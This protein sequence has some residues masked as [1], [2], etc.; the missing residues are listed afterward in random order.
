MRNLIIIN[1]SEGAALIRSARVLDAFFWRVGRSTW[2]G[3]ASDA[4]LKRVAKELRARASRNTAVAFHVAREGSDYRDPILVVGSRSS[5]GPRGV[6]PVSRRKAPEMPAPSPARRRSAAVLRV[7]ALLHDLGKAGSDFQRKLD[8]S[9]GDPA[10][11]I[12]DQARH[13]LISFALWDVAYGGMDDETLGAA[14]RAYDPAAITSAWESLGSRKMVGRYFARSEMLEK[15]ILATCLPSSGLSRT[16]GLL[17]LSHHRLPASDGEH[18]LS[19]GNHVR[20][21]DERGRIPAIGY[22]DPGPDGPFWA[23]PAFVAA[24]RAAGEA[25]TPGPVLMPDLVLRTALMLG[26]HHGSSLKSPSAER[27]AHVANLIGGEWADGLDVHTDRV[28][29]WSSAALRALEGSFPEIRPRD[30]PDGVARP[31]IEGLYG[32]QGRAAAA[33]AEVAAEGAAFFACVISGTGTGKTFGLPAI[34]AAAAR[35]HPDPAMRGLRFFLGQGLRT[36]ST[37]SARA[38]V[39]DAGFPASAVRAAVGRPVVRIPDAGEAQGS[40]SLD[41]T[42]DLTSAAVGAEMIAEPLPAPLDVMFPDPGDA[43][44]IA[45]PIVAGTIDQIAASAT[46]LR[47]F[48]LSASV[49]VI[50]SDLMLDEIDQLAPEQLFIAYALIRQAAACGRRVIVASA[51]LPPDVA[52]RAFDAFRAGVAERAAWLGE[53]PRICVLVTGDAPGALAFSPDAREI[54]PLYD[55][56]VTAQ[57]AAARDPHVVPEVMGSGRG[58]DGIVNAISA[59]CDLQHERHAVS[60]VSAGLIR[61]G[62]VATASALAAA[63][64]E[65]PS[66]VAERKVILLHSR[67]TGAARAMVEDWLRRA[68]NRKRDPRGALPGMLDEMAPGRGG[69]TQLVVISSPV[70]ETGNDLD[71]DY[72]IIDPTDARSVV[73][74]AGRVRRHRRDTP[75]GPNLSILDVPL[76]IA[77]GEDL[78][79]NPGPESDPV[80]GRKVLIG[81]ARAS[82]RALLGSLTEAVSPSAILTGDPESPAVGFEAEGREAAFEPDGSGPSA[83]DPAARGETERFAADLLRRRRLRRE[84][85]PSTEVTR[86]FGDGWVGDRWTARFRREPP[87]GF[88]PRPG[89]PA[90]TLALIPDPEAIGIGLITA[91][92]GAIGPAAMSISVPFRETN[93]KPFGSMSY[94]PFFGM[95]PPTHDPWSPFG[96]SARG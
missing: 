11:R 50:S 22:P 53:T 3:R 12:A 2:R 90:P 79:R 72:A 44:L 61:V 81:E 39:E 94:A 60:G 96:K 58:W 17:I 42:Q 26:D 46:P 15:R 4:C 34:I 59:R 80:P 24:M 87:V 54:G 18:A 10:A 73:Q 85:M 82:A 41:A 62:R 5:F 16:I 8:R 20:D 6:V 28:V 95:G 30:V 65:M 36:L 69:E 71:F 35:A 25:L 27:P 83:F 66:T 74:A 76:Q 21:A 40:E 89:R 49:R 1:E 13:E 32:W 43:G 78:L 51:T 91:G 56:C 68:L 29:T 47:S 48:H 64:G 19:T 7:A 37:Q 55:A 75:S 93:E 77:A 14:L 33:A 57:V 45:A 52:R 67:L 70:I 86:S 88:V 63:L 23:T 31:P 84:T 9:H 92:G 38:Y